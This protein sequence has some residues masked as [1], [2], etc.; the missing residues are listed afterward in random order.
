[1][2][3]STYL[4]TFLA[5]SMGIVLVLPYWAE[6]GDTVTEKSDAVVAEGTY[7]FLTP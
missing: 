3:K 7:L 1:M 6:G 2:S 4:R 5:L